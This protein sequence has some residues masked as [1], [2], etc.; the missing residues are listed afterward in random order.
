MKQAGVHHTAMRRPMR[1]PWACLRGLKPFEIA[2]SDRFDSA[3]RQFGR[4]P[5]DRRYGCFTARIGTAHLDD[6]SWR[7]LRPVGPKVD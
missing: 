5:G 7:S 2:R 3:K 1:V 4:P 6:E